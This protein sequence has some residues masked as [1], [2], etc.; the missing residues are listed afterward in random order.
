MI[1]GLR[2]FVLGLPISVSPIVLHPAFLIS[3]TEDS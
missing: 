1:Q 3:D 2:F